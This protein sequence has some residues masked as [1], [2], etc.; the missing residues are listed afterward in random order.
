MPSLF[1]LLQLA[2]APYGDEAGASVLYA[3]TN[4]FVDPATESIYVMESVPGTAQALGDCGLV[5]PL[6]LTSDLRPGSRRLFACAS[7]SNRLFLI[8]AI[9]GSGTD[10]GWFGTTSPMQSL[11]FD[12]LSGTLYGVTLD[13]VLYEID[14]DTG[15]G[16][17]IG[18]VGY[19]S[20]LA[21]EFDPGGTLYGVSNDADLLIV[22]DT[23][24]GAGTFVAPTLPAITGMAR[25][26]EDDV[27][28]VVETA[29]DT[30]HRLDLTDGSTKEIGPYGGGVQYMVGIAFLM[31][32]I[33]C[34]HGTVNLANTNFPAGVL[35]VADGLGDPE[36]TVTIEAGVPFDIRVDLPPDRPSGSAPFAMYVWRGVPDESTISPQPSGLGE[37]CMPT[38]LTGGVPLPIKIWN[39]I[40]KE[41]ALGEPDHP[42]TPAP[43]TIVSLAPGRT[44]PITVTLQGFIVDDGSAAEVPASV[45]NAVTLEIHDQM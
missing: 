37:M 19:P 45:T 28:F 39:N 22:I 21:L 20:I 32:E 31:P 8:D 5:R 23:V 42:S 41:G 10:V 1:L 9:S 15:M 7:L 4:E 25:R 2:I 34:F 13:S 26:P 16:T 14:T 12:S 35:H 6:D 44:R 36:R 33:E 40:G 17:E 30:I 27:M 3:T 24:T 43:S 11:A 29:R 38:F 18:P